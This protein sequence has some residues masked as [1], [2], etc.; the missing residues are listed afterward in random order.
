MKCELNSNPI[1]IQNTITGVNKPYNGHNAIIK[2]MKHTLPKNVDIGIKLGQY[3]SHG[4]V[5]F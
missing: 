3:I 5:T 2:Q 4:M 1:N